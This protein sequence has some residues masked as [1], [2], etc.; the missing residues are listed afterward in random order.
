MPRAVGP[1]HCL[2]YVEQTRYDETPMKAIITG[3]TVIDVL[4]PGAQLADNPAAAEQLVEHLA[5]Q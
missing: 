4:P 5:G 2:C 1:R 3:D